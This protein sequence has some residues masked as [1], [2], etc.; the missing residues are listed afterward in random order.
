MNDKIKLLVISPYETLSKTIIQ[1]SEN[2][3]QLDI[4]VEVGCIL[5][6]V[7]LMKKHNLD[8]FD[9]ILSRGGTKMEIEKNTTLPVFEIPISYFDLLNII[10][11][12]EHYKGKVAILMYENIANAAR[13][14]CKILQYTC[15][16]FIIDKW[17]N[18]AEKVEMLKSQG[19]SLIIGDAVSVQYAEKIG[20]QNI[21]LTSGAD[22]VRQALEQIVH[23][24]SYLTRYKRESRLYNNFHKAIQEAFLFISAKGDILDSTLP[25]ELHRLQTTCRHLLPQVRE[26]RKLVVR[27]SLKE[28]FFEI[29]AALISIQGEFVSVFRIKRLYFAIAEANL[30]GYLTF[31]DLNEKESSEL[32]N[33]L[34]LVEPALWQQAQQAV[35][36]KTPICVRGPMG[37]ETDQFIK[38]LFTKNR[39]NQGPLYVIDGTLINTA[40]IKDIC[41]S[42]HSPLFITDASVYFKHLEAMDGRL[43]AF[44]ADELIAASYISTARLFFSLES[45]ATEEILTERFHN[46]LDQFHALPVVLPLLAHKEDAILN[47][48]LLY[49]HHHNHLQDTHIVGM[50]PEAITL[51][52]QYPWPHNLSQLQRVLQ[53]A[54]LTTDAPWITAKTLRQILKNEDRSILPPAQENLDLERPLDEIIHSVI[55]QVL[56]QEDMNQSRTAVRLGISRTTLWRLLKEDRTKK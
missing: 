11:L 54:I 26:K 24:C 13:A 3:P 21:L 49:I 15:D 8:D 33:M 41:S 2:F 29:T 45:Q 46:L 44:L 34:Q 32:P 27:K 38:Q 9:A 12:V 20:I 56:Q 23:S 17:H 30:P 35:E 47:Y 51:L 31:Y 43:F 19:Y 53:Q 4:T 25:K 40:E 18:A 5:E 7:R 6:G 1:I 55:L 50:E 16:I 52:C 22:S 37:S 42:Q 36:N 39:H 10:K 48:A 28:G 14:L